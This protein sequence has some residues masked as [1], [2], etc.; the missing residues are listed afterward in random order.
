MLVGLLH[1]RALQPGKEVLQTP[2]IFFVLAKIGVPLHCGQPCLGLEVP[3]CLLPA[4]APAVLGLPPFAVSLARNL[5]SVPGRGSLLLITLVIYCVAAV[6]GC[7]W[8]ART[9]RAAL[10]CFDP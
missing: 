3:G 9:T 8:R 7:N 10:S 2:S 5:V 4:A 6:N 1:P